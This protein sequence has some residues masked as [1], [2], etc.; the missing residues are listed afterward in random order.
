MDPYSR[1]NQIRMNL[2]DEEKMTL[3]TDRGLYC[4]TTMSFG[5]ENVGATYQQLVN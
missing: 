1:Y 5:L 2:A 4:Y 3:V